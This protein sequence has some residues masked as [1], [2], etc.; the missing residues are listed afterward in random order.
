MKC[1]SAYLCRNPKAK[2]RLQERRQTK[3]KETKKSRRTARR[4]TTPIRATSKMNAGTRIRGETRRTVQKSRPRKLGS[5]ETTPGVKRI[6]GNATIIQ[7]LR[8]NLQ[9]ILAV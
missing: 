6:A 9:G 4:T 8:R 7:S 5:N 3:R 2:P 1:C